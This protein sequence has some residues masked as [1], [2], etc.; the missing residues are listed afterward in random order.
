MRFCIYNFNAIILLMLYNNAMS[1]KKYHPDSPHTYA[2]GFF[3][4]LE[5]LNHAPKRCLAVLYD[6]RAQKSEALTKIEALCS[7]HNI[8]FVLDDKTVSRLSPSENTFVITVIEK[9][10]V[11]LG[12]DDNHLVLVS[13]S[14]MGNL[15]TI[16]RTA[17]GFKMRHIALIQP[18]A[19]EA[20]PRVIRAS[21]G[22]VFR[23]HIQK[24]GTYDDYSAQ[25]PRHN[26]YPMMTDGAIPLADVS[27]TPPYRLIF[28]N[29][30]A[31]LP[32]HFAHLGQSVVIPH[33][34]AIDSLNLAIAVGVVLYV[35]SQ[36]NP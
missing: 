6:T 15:G 24:F 35:A 21:M 29:E 22:A 36:K 28:G 7:A 26:A 34:D 25:F 3:P 10:R 18:C 4:S 13:P 31:G 23:L 12:A 8:P 5:A 14:D 16:F 20:D 17:L 19:D 1:Y 33:S 30:S 2:F 32:P 11:R 9:T 27:F